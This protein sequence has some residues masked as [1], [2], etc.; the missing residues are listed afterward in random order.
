MQIM[1]WNDGCA[2][3]SKLK[4][5]SAERLHG[6]QATLRGPAAAAGAAGRVTDAQAKMVADAL[7][8]DALQRNTL[9]N[10]TVICLLPQWD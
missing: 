7:V 9:D 1:A 4:S 5:A 8:M 10:V 3:V 6:V 2:G